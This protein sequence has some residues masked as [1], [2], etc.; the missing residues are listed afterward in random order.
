MIN[1]S[2]A[3]FRRIRLTL[4]QLWKV[5][6]IDPHDLS[7]DYKDKSTKVADADE[8]KAVAAYKKRRRDDNAKR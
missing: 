4:D 1:D 2:F 5:F 7:W 3:W 8:D 6:G